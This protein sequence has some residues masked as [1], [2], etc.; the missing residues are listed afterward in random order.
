MQG[1]ARYAELARGTPHRAPVPLEC[2]SHGLEG[3]CV[4]G[5]EERAQG[6]W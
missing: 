1:R 3:Q 5:G 4:A 2:A 6:S